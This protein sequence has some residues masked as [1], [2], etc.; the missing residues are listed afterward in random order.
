M[1]DKLKYYCLGPYIQ[2]QVFKSNCNL[3]RYQVRF[4]LKDLVLEF[5]EYDF[6]SLL[7]F[8]NIAPHL[9]LY[10]FGLEPMTTYFHYKS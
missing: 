9:Y 3:A 5:L 2:V 7:S 10:S 8:N 4:D 6:F 1:L